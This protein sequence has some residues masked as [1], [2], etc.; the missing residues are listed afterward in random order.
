MSG[1]PRKALLEVGGDGR[2]LRE[3]GQ[4]AGGRGGPPLKASDM[5]RYRDQSQAAGVQH[6][7]P[8]ARERSKGLKTGCQG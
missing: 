2:S 3:A 5:A 6:Q 1:S 8:V 4:L 7:R